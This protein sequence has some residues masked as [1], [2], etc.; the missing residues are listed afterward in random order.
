VNIALGNA[1]VSDC[2]AGNSN[3]D[4]RIS[5]DEILKAVNKALNGC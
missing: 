2:L 1:S 4:D 3:G 5:V